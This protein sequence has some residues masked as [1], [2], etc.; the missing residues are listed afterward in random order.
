MLEFGAHQ[1]IFKIQNIVFRI[2]HL[3]NVS[4]KSIG[5]CVKLSVTCFFIYGKIIE[6]S[7]VKSYAVVSI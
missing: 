7:Q 4:F 1:N 2:F 3:G 5:S 6:N